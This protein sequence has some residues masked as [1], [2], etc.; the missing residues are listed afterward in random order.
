[1]DAPFR[2]RIDRDAFHDPMR[3]LCLLGLVAMFDPPRPEDADAVAACR[4]AGIRIIVITDDNGL[5]AA[6]VA[7]APAILVGKRAG[8]WVAFV[9][10]R[11][12][13]PGG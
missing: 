1:V 9:S 13:N 10:T 7:P 4:R 11:D 3:D 12:E 8:G 5:T 6:A 2:R